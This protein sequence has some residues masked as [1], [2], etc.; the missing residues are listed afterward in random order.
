MQVIL[1]ATSVRD[2]IA[3]W[4]GTESHLSLGLSRITGSSLVGGQGDPPPMSWKS[5]KSFHAFLCVCTCVRVYACVQC[6][7]VHMCLCVHACV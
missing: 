2:Q 3:S 5:L 6:V 1:G 7:H 4:S